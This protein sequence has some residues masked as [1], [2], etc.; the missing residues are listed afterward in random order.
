MSTTEQIKDA[1]NAKTKE[2]MQQQQQSLAKNKKKKH[3]KEQAPEVADIVAGSAMGVGHDELVAATTTQAGDGKSDTHFSKIDVSRVTLSADRKQ[4]SRSNKKQKKGA[5]AAKTEPPPTDEEFVKVFYQRVPNGAKSELQ[6]E[7]GSF[8]LGTSSILDWEGTLAKKKADKSHENVRGDCYF[9]AI[10][11]AG[12]LEGRTDEDNLTAEQRECLEKIYELSTHTLKLMFRAKQY[13]KFRLEAIEKAQDNMKQDYIE[14]SDKHRGNHRAV[15]SPTEIDEIEEKNPDLVATMLAEAEKIFLENAN[16]YPGRPEPED[17]AAGF[18]T[19]QMVTLRQKVWPFGKDKFDKSRDS[20]TKFEPLP[21]VK[22]DYESWPEIYA[23]MTGPVGRR[24]YNPLIF[25]NG[26]TGQVLPRPPVYLE[27]TFVNE[28]GQR[29]TEKQK[30]ADPGWNPTVRKTVKTVDEKG[31]TIDEKTVDI[32]CLVTGVVKLMPYSGPDQYGVRLVVK[33]V[34]SIVDHVPR[35]QRIITSNA[36]YARSYDYDDTIRI[37][38]PKSSTAVTTKKSKKHA[39]A[40]DDDDNEESGSYEES[41]DESSSKSNGA[42]HPQ[43]QQQAPLQQQQPQ[44]QPDQI[45]S[46]ETK[47]PKHQEPASTP[48]PQQHQQTT[49]PLPADVPN[50]H[51]SRHA[52]P[53][54]TMPLEPQASVATATTAAASPAKDSVSRHRHSAVPIMPP[55]TTAV[56]TAAVAEV[57]AA[58]NSMAIDTTQKSQKRS[59]STRDEDPIVEQLPPKSATP[60]AIVPPSPNRHAIKIPTLAEAQQSE[61]GSGSEDDDDEDDE[62]ESESE[63]SSEESAPPPPPPPQKHAKHSSEHKKKKAKTT[64]VVQESRPLSD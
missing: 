28:A 36:K 11:W 2:F 14:R 46:K 3:R 26:T 27:T 16:Q 51:R 10:L 9:S 6:F 15:L 62:Y 32:V 49:Q 40:N 59:R 39:V 42:A 25:A 8:V 47:K 56:A 57:A 45:P 18:K 24:Y 4:Y 13:E 55:K 48:Q 34:I 1:I 38:A 29:V 30:Y 35:T 50:G 54:A 61:E 22:S 20:K 31:R 5:K 44:Q 17:L 58:T 60:T 53:T 21:G 52:V 41:D 37:A 12:L 64:H 7:I 33:E 23:A 43:Q 19:A 63:E